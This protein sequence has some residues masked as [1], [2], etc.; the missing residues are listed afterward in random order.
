MQDILPVEISGA[1]DTV[2]GTYMSTD[3]KLNGRTVF[4]KL[5]SAECFIIRRK[6]RKWA[7]G[8]TQDDIVDNARNAGLAH[9][10]EADLLHP[11]LAKAWEVLDDKAQQPIVAS[12]TVGFDSVTQTCI[13]DRSRPK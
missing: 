1:L 12:I 2:N 5:G 7:A 8:A 6:D 4:S 11:A 3:K 9:T 13:V 10:V